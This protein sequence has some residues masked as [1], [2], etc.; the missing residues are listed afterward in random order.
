MP[1][2]PDQHHLFKV[3]HVNNDGENHQGYKWIGVDDDFVTAAAQGLFRYMN[4]PPKKQF[5]I[6]SVV[7]YAATVHVTLV[8]DDEPA[9]INLNLQL[10]WLEHANA[11]EEFRETNKIA[12]SRIY[13]NKYGSLT[14]IGETQKLSNI[15]QGDGSVTSTQVD[16]DG[17][18]NVNDFYHYPPPH[19]NFPNGINVGSHLGFIVTH[20]GRNNMKLYGNAETDFFCMIA[21]SIV[22]YPLPQK[23]SGL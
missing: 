22:D 18:R 21:Y 19:W 4:A 17:I 8:N 20:G 9:S 5:R 11:V 1:K 16:I 15:D 7:L 12:F 10:K 2:Y 6:Y 13:Y 14:K 3:L 23:I